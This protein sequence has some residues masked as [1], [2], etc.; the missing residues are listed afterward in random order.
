[1]SRCLLT[2]TAIVLLTATALHSWAAQDGGQEGSPLGAGNSL[3]GGE[4]NGTF[5]DTLAS[6]DTGPLMVV[7][8]AGSFRMGCLNEGGG[9]YVSQTPVRTVNIPSF[10]ISRYETTFE[11]WDACVDAGGC[12]GYRPDDRGWG[13]GDRPAIRLRWGDAQS[14]VSWLSQQT[15]K[16]YRLPSESEWEYAARAGTETTYS[17]GRRIGRNRANCD[18][19]GSQWD[20]TQTAPV[21]SFAPNPWG[22]YDIHGN[23]FE[24]TQ[25]C[26]GDLT[27]AGA[28]T[29]GSASLAGPCSMRILRGGGWD[30]HP[31]FCR[32]SYRSSADVDLGTDVLGLR[33]VRTLEPVDG[34]SGGGSSGSGGGGGAANRP[35][36]VEREIPPQTLDVGKT[37]TLDIRLSFYDRDQRALD[38]TV[39]SADA[40]VAT[41]EIDDREQTLTL[42]GVGRGRTTLTVTAADRRNETASQTVPVTV[43]GPALLA[44]VPRASHPVLEGFLRVVNRSAEDAEIFVE[45]TDDRGMTADVVTL[46]IPAGETV[47]F[48]STDLE[49]G[50]A[51]KGLAQGVGTGEGD[52]RLVLDAETDFDAF[53]YMRTTDGFLTAMHDVVPAENGSHGVRIFN[54]GSNVNQVSRLRIVNPG[55][56]DAAVTIAGI[57]DAGISPGS[58]V[59]FDVPAGTAV[60]L[61][62]SDLESGNGLEGALGDGAGKWRLTVDS[63]HP[64]TVMNLL[65]SPTGHLTNLS[66]A[67]ASGLAGEP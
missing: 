15:G 58:A 38:Y 47:H 61:T 25:D 30:N 34:G 23:V 4:A 13:R 43:L 26:R 42:R 20:A 50:N 3:S 33:V 63:S 36:V 66:T 29:D 14:Y 57:D 60:T 55:T 52:W 31:D 64:V 28:P 45:A 21:G 12:N 5:T 32:A 39:E 62:A 37:A 9:C 54:P 24:W 48:N 59:A 1:M 19:C 6:G 22:L 51:A 41:A 44:Y 11:Q 27:Y 10:A 7:I 2:R 56:E 67:P 40:S 18:G 53:A 17:W 49:M 46:E 16:Q 65:S 35:P 8:P